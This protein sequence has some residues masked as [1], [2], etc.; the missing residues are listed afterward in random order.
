MEGE[1]ENL[2]PHVQQQ[3]THSL[4]AKEGETIVQLHSYVHELLPTLLEVD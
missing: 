4:D 1:F 3:T 2:Y